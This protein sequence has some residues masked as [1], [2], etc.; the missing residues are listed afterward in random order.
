MKLEITKRRHLEN[1]ALMKI[2]HSG[3]T[4]TSSCLVH[5][6][7]NYQID[8]KK[9]KKTKTNIQTNKPAY[10]RPTTVRILL[11]LLL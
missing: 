6:T 4:G 7:M 5:K 11:Q 1:S 10:Q 3:G 2:Q 8:K 9:N